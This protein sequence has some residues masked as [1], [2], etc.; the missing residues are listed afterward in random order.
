[1][2]KASELQVELTGAT[3]LRADE[4]AAWEGLRASNPDLWSPFFDHRFVTLA[5]AHAPKAGLAV[6]RRRGR[7]VGFLPFQ[8]NPRGVIRPLSAPLA[9]Q[10]G[11][12]TSPDGPDVASV[13]AVMGTRQFGFGG[14][15]GPVDR[16]CTT[17]HPLI[18]LVDFSAGVDAYLRARSEAWGEHFRKLARR[19]R[20]AEREFGPVSFAGGLSDPGLLAALIARKSQQYRATGRHDIL[21]VQWIKN[22]LEALLAC[23]SGDFGG[24]L[25]ALWY[26]EELVAVEFG[27]RSGDVLHSWFPVFDH[28]F[29]SVAPGVALM[30]AMILDAGRRGLRIVDLGAGHDS[31][32]KHVSNRTMQVHAGAIVA[33]GLRASLRG[34]AGA[35]A[36]R[37][38]ASAL[39]PV[40]ALPGRLSRRLEMI[41]ASEPTLAGRLRGLWWAARNLA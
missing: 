4:R 33:S 3:S 17:Q 21:S 37:L 34:L 36:E 16:T 1:M 10:H 14:L 26:G 6:V 22:L 8:G 5:A 25:A 40:A 15:V 39:K 12:I 29:A 27:M 20:K 32:K 28:R 7:I 19:E 13:L 30:D 11:L 9:D 41:L 18:H 24:E 2:E 31:Y 38:E 35:V 23:N